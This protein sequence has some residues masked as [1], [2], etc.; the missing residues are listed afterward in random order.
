MEK[1][2]KS[3]IHG[4]FLPMLWLVSQPV[5]SGTVHALRSPAPFLGLQ[6]RDSNSP[7]SPTKWPINWLI[8][9]LKMVI[10]HSYVFPHRVLQ[11]NMDVS[12]ARPLRCTEAHGPW[13]VA[14]YRCG[15]ANRPFPAASAP[16][17]SQIGHKT[18]S[19]V[20]A[21]RKP[22]GESWWAILRDS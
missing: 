18:T 13:P 17:S 10:F 1:C 21:H 16:R 5:S 8:H 14:R 9:L 6:Q 3:A 7:G 15:P 19:P 4:W 22:M 20:G 2:G 11:K 12:Y